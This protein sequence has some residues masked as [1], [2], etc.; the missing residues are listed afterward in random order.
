MQLLKIRLT[1]SA[2][3]EVRQKKVGEERLTKDAEETEASETS[4]KFESV[5]SRLKQYKR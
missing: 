2:H 5:P 1:V 3:I 4:L